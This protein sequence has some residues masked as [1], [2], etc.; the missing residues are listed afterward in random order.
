MKILITGGYG[1]IGTNFIHY[2]LK[3]RP[4]IK[5][6]NL[7]LLT[8]SGNPENLKSIEKHPDY[9][10]IKGDIA[11]RKT[12]SEVF[13]EDIDVVINFAA[14]SHV[15]RS[16]EDAAPFVRT[17]VLGAQ[18]LMD[19]ARRKKVKRFIQISTDE[20]YGSILG[21]AKFREDFPLLPNSPYSASKAAADLV[22]RGYFKTYRFPVMISRASNN[23]G[24]YQFPEKFIPLLVAN[25]LQG[26]TL[27]IYGDGL[28]VRDWLYVEDNCAAILKIM[29]EGREGEIYNVGGDSERQNIDVAKKVLG[30]TGM[31]ESLLEH[32]ADRPGHDRRY[33][34]DFTKIKN[35][36]GFTPSVPFEE[37]I[38]RTISWYK[39]N[40]SWWRRIISGDYLVD[41]KEAY[42][43]FYGD[44]TKI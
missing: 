9:H 34:I 33:A 29:E 19:E 38:K 14:E 30:L 25:A 32:V 31:D 21:D 16:I 28:H 13:S 12:L 20:V 26:K 6:I 27:P 1:F 39:E 42:K 17:N 10:F 22:A 7:D 11:D 2:L 41:R 8:Y 43:Q 15:D 18:R 35:E 5:I 40:E 23:Y 36:L 4:G 44:H 24:P 3:K 37:G